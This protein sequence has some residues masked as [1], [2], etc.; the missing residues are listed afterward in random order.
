MQQEGFWRHTSERI[1]RECT[2]V[3]GRFRRTILQY[4]EQNL[5]AYPDPPAFDRTIDRLT[6]R[7]V[8]AFSSNREQSVLHSFVRGNM[9]DLRNAVF[10]TEEERRAFRRD[11][12]D[13][14]KGTLESLDRDCRDDPTAPVFC[15]T[16]CPDD[17]DAHFPE[18]KSSLIDALQYEPDTLVVLDSY[19][20][21]V[22]RI[23]EEVCFVTADNAH[24]LRNHDRIEEIL[25]GIT[26]RNPD[27][28]LAGEGG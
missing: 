14:I 28:F 18:Q 8:R 10:G 23:R 15:Y 26:V 7:R 17:Y 20:L 1:Y 25:P 6:E 11:A 4:L 21:Q 27:S 24:I 12:I 13:A 16:C 5:P 22:H 2:G 9:E 19:F 3:P